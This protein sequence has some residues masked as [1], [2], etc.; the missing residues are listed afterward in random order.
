LQALANRAASTP[1]LVK[2]SIYLNGSPANLHTLRRIS[3]HVEQKDGLIGSLTVRETLDFAV[4]ISL[5]KHV[6]RSE[7]IQ[8]VES[9][10]AAFGLR[11]QAE[12]LIG[13]RVKSG[14]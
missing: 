14:I 10:L 3:A 13:T 12:N 1:A 9:L 5:S 7:R 4:R 11:G 2:A 8:R 6:S